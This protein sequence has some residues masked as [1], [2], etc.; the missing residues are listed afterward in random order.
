MV[1]I[2]EAVWLGESLSA[3][4]VEPPS[5]VRVRAAGH[6]DRRGGCVV[7]AL[8]PGRAGAHQLRDAAAGR[9]RHRRGG[10]AGPCL[11][12]DRLGALARP[13][14]RRAWVA[15]SVVS[16]S[17]SPRDHRRPYRR[18]HAPHRVA[19]ARALSRTAALIA[20]ARPPMGAGVA[21]VL[22]AADESPR[23]G[24]SADRIRHG[25]DPGRLGA[26]DDVDLVAGRIDRH[27]DRHRGQRTSS[28][29]SGRPSRRPAPAPGHA[30]SM[31]PAGS[32]PPQDT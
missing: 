31:P 5:E 26:P 23:D 20:T 29:R 16:C 17:P 27:E 6:R 21:K 7:G 19:A 12:G 3:A 14:R 18:G 22:S 13:P 24:V 1:G 28:W 2:P 9:R 4:V 30:S 32:P 15:P 10:G 11:A 25:T 8:A